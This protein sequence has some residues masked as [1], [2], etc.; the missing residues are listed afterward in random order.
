MWGTACGCAGAA[1]SASLK[2][3]WRRHFASRRGRRSGICERF[4]RDWRA[5]RRRLPD[6]CIRTWRWEWIDGTFDGLLDGLSRA[7]LISISSDTFTNA[8]G[9]AISYKKATLTGEGRE[10][11]GTG[12]VPLQVKL[13]EMESPATKAKGRSVAKPGAGLAK[14]MQEEAAAAYSAEQKQI[15]TRLREWRKAEAGKTGKPG[16]LIFSDSTLHALVVAQPRSMS[17][18][19][20]VS[21]IGTEKAERYG[22]AVIALIRDQEATSTVFTSASSP[23]VPHS[24]AQFAA[25]S[26]K[27][28]SPLSS[29]PKNTQ[30]KKEERVA[31]SSLRQRSK[32]MAEDLTPINL[33]PRGGRRR[34]KEYDR[35][36]NRRLDFEQ[37]LRA[38]GDE[39]ARRLGLN[40]TE[41]FSEAAIAEILRS[42]PRTL[43]DLKHLQNLSQNLGPEFYDELQ[44]T[45][46]YEYLPEGEKTE[47]PQ[48]ERT[49][50]DEVYMRRPSTALIRARSV[51]QQSETLLTDEQQ[52]L[53]QRLRE[54]RKSE[55]EKLGLPQFFV[56]GSSALR[57]IVMEHPKTLEQLK[58]MD[59]LSSEKFDKYGMGILGVCNAEMGLRHE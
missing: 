13:K 28:A 7:G 1:I 57:S 56:L 45:C 24:V 54:W 25:P 18:L 30:N 49:A 48:F 38:F 19:L 53:D 26:L 43:L 36:A 15:E 17:S 59:G 31:A 14:A 35:A 41:F 47:H 20:Q 4:C 52:E 27:N 23:S 39:M 44:K 21:G 3:P 55:S 5:G 8:E 11:T 46:A 2:G 22:P 12:R 10:H 16:F 58:K 40:V 33:H 37:D 29:L 50:V 6:G 42:R 32:H 51:D 9:V 34:S